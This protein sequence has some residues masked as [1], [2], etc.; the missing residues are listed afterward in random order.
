VI[1]LHNQLW[2]SLAWDKMRAGLKFSWVLAYRSMALLIGKQL[3]PRICHA[4]PRD[5]VCEG[6]VPGPAEAM[7][8][9]SARVVTL[10]PA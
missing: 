7:R 10:F 6:L 9:K 8:G 3:L 2:G 1:L 4:L 5:A